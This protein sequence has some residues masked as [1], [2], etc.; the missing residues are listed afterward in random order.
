MLVLGPLGEVIVHVLEV[1]GWGHS[2][3]TMTS[4]ME[5]LLILPVHHHGRVVEIGASINRGGDWLAMA[6]PTHL[7]AIADYARC[8]ISKQWRRQKNCLSIN[9]KV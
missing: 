5:I 4:R 7:L 3:R 9:S 2:G 8:R 1:I 6:N